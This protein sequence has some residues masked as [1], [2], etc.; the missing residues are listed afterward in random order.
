MLN[1][2]IAPTTHHTLVN[3]L[4]VVLREVHS[5]PVASWYV[6]YRIGSRNE[7][8]GQTGISH[9]VE[10]MMFKGTQRF[11]AGVLDKTIDRMGGNWNAFTSTDVTM[12]H[13]T[14][15]AQHLR[16]ALE[17]EADRMSNAVFD[18]EEVES[19]RTVIISERQGIENRPTFWLGEQTRASAFRVHG[20]H[21]E[22]IGDLTD[23][24][25]ITRDDLY[26]HYR[27]HY[28]P[29]NAI[30]VAVGDFDSDNLFAQI[31]EYYGVLPSVPAPRLFSRPEP[32]QLGE[33]RVI[34][35]RVVQT[36]FVR[37]CYH[38][39]AATDD[40]W[41]ALAMLDAILS[42]AG[43]ENKTSRLYQAMVKSGL[44]AGASGSLQETIDPFLYSISLTLNAE[45][46]HA[47]AEAALFAQIER[48][49]NDLISEAELHRAMKQSSA[50][51]AYVSEGV[52]Y[53]A[54]A[55]AMSSI[56]GQPDWFDTYL[57]RLARVTAEDVRQAAQKY[58][59]SRNRTVGWLV[60]S[61]AN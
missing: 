15:P 51:F 24:H 7:R 57:E 21:H 31:E 20:Y 6:A 49:Q 53:Q 2:L 16:L 9:W 32:E 34:V 54:S 47:Q 19:E 60:P 13:E 55:L 33:R 3:G 25:T 37:V 17:A 14:L 56:L 5:A 36:R 30:V 40:D 11:P 45:T 10:H 35:E 46:T 61:E 27:Q 18:P 42:G 38:V 52:S 28:V 12:Y 8:T 44:C 26:N 22:I 23:L 29:S 58:L 50:S 59:T 43:M 1:S 41:F 4:S 48:L 39:P